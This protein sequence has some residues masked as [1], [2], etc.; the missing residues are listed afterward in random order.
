MLLF[1]D[2]AGVFLKE[3]NKT[4]MKC[5]TIRFKTTRNYATQYSVD[6]FTGPQSTYNSTA[7]ALGPLKATYLFITLNMWNDCQKEHSNLLSDNILNNF[8]AKCNIY[9]K[10]ATNAE[11]ALTSE[12]DCLVVQ[13]SLLETKHNKLL[14]FFLTV[15]VRM[16]Y[17]LPEAKFRRSICLS[18]FMYTML[19]YAQVYTTNEI[20]ISF[21]FCSLT[22][23]K[24]GIN[25]NWSQ[26]SGC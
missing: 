7:R 17:H 10:T 26:D 14:S 12:Q 21:Y 6:M 22:T 1:P 5:K 13:M 11:V 24:Q 4:P 9:D 25:D 3:Q 2:L 16:F 18:F 8:H 15:H 19:E 20:T 23:I